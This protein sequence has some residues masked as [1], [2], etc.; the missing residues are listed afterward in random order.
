MHSEFSV[1]VEGLSKRYLIN[2]KPLDILKTSL[3][4]RFRR[5]LGLINLQKRTEEFWAIKDL[6]IRIRKVETVGIIGANGS[7]KST[8]LQLISGTLSPTSGEIHK[9]GKVAALL[10]LGSGFNLEFT[11]R[12]NIYLNASILGLSKKEIEK[13]FESIEKF[14]DIGEF[15]DQPVKT[16]SSGMYV[17]LAFAVVAHVD[18]DILIVDEALAVGDAIFTQKCMRFIRKFK[19]SGALLF[20]SHD[21]STIMNLCDR[22]IWLE[23]GKI[24]LEGSAKS[25]GEAYL[26]YTLQQVYGHEIE[27]N[28]LQDVSNKVTQEKTI[29]PEDSDAEIQVDYGGLF[30]ID[31]KLS[32]SSGWITGNGEIISVKVQ[33]IHGEEIGLFK[34]GE[35]IRLIISAKIIKSMRSPIL[36]FLIRDKLG[37]DLFGENTLPYTDKNQISSD[38]RT[39]LEAEF[40]FKIPMLPNGAYSVV[41]A[42]ADGDAYDHVQH[43]WLHEAAI[44]NVSSSA[45]RWGIVGIEIKKIVLR[46]FHE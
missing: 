41:A 8:L 43:H 2:K 15:M 13:R 6:S 25:V 42:L 45:L 36:G 3:L 11:G 40:E 7:G 44:I 46:N 12:E 19:K 21:L 29:A 32:E 4:S 1:V 24:M 9:N 27:F 16:Y 39:S 35:V 26:Q 17:R 14:A 30:K 22:A 5:Y 38:A 23:K 33:N 18:A 10:E 28:K 31:E 34:G 37:Q 20:V